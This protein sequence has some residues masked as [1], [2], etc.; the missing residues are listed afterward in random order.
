M[1]MVS[2]AQSGPAREA[3][4]RISQTAPMPVSYHRYVDFLSIRIWDQI[5]D[6]KLGL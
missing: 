6:C 1:N 3:P 2:F 5:P 4:R